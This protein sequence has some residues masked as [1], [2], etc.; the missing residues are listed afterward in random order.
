M[1]YIA[2]K[3]IKVQKSDGVIDIRKPGEEVPEAK[4]WPNAALWI[5]RGYIMP[6][7]QESA[8]TAGLVREKLKPMVPADRAAVER[9]KAPV[10]QAGE[11]L[12]GYQGQMS[13]SKTDAGSSP[14]FD[15]LSPGEKQY[16]RE[17]EDLT[18][19]DLNTLATEHGIKD[20]HRLPNKRAVAIDIVWA[21][22][23]DEEDG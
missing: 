7:D 9:G 13:T 8:V 6:T 18:R 20:A 17:L 15:E 12:P 11:D 10:P 14:G 23:K 19:E 5:K 1:G 4:D 16:V 2:V 21:D 22:R 3:S